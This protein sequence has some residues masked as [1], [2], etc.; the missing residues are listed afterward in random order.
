[1]EKWQQGNKFQLCLTRKQE[2]ILL[3]WIGSCRFIYNAGLEH[4]VASYNAQYPKRVFYSEQQDSLPQI[5]A[6][7]NFFW[8]K[9]TPSQSLQFSLR[10]LDNAFSRFFQGLGKFPK[11]KK[12]GSGGITFPQGNKLGIASKSNKKSVVKIPKLGNI[13]F[14]H[15]RKLI[16]KIK[17]ANI[18]LKAGKFFIS[19]LTEEEKILPLRPLEIENAIGI[20]MGME[21]SIAISNGKY[22]H[23]NVEKIKGIEKR[24]EK[25]QRKMA[26][27]EKFSKRWHYFQKITSR[28][29]SEIA[30]IRRDFLHQK[31]RELAENQSIVC[32][33]DLR[34][35]NM[36]KSA[37]GT[38]ENPGKNVAQKSGLNRGILRQGWGMF[39]TMLEYKCKKFGTTLELVNPRNT[40]RKC[41]M[42]GHTSIENRQSQ[43]NFLCV[44][45]GHNENA[46][47]HAAKNIL[48]I[49]LDS[50][51]L[52][53]ALEAPTIIGQA[54]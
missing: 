43:E 35:K 19:F 24:V 20:D 4:R 8:L 7:P 27:R 11:K 54:I 23:L 22:F 21:K 25:I 36:T 26:K 18:S 3:Q 31:S 51:G 53:R 28:L 30:D 52:K 46:D 33:E 44:E 37:S 9:D 39:R 5:K 13:K 40:S 34:V 48:R 12:K 10:N 17:S 6:E 47:I 29:H 49:G 41:R 38:L 15:H 1:M 14:I 45:C 16:G 42:C 2:I 32:M 50:L